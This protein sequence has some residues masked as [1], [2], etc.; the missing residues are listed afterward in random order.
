MDQT[1]AD[2]CENMKSGEF[3]HVFPDDFRAKLW[4]ILFAGAIFDFFAVI[5]LC[6]AENGGRWAQLYLVWW[7]DE[8]W[9]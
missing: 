1:D 9:T 7:H 4:M 2:D 5:S 3:G 8:E 6:A